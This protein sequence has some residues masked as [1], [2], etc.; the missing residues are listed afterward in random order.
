MYLPDGNGLEL[1]KWIRLY[2]IDVGVIL[3]NADKRIQST[4]ESR[5]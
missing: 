3:I 2:D 4:K 1:P 5:K